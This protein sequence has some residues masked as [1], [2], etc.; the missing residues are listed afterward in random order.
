MKI[1]ELIF[2]HTGNGKKISILDDLSGKQGWLQAKQITISSF[3][4]E[5][6]DVQTDSRIGRKATANLIQNPFQIGSVNRHLP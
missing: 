6:M 3:E 1:K 4:M 2:D 5:D